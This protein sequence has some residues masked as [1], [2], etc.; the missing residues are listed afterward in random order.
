[1]KSTWFVF[2]VLAS[3]LCGANQ[4]RKAPKPPDVEVVEVTARRSQGAIAIDGRVRNC[5]ERPIPSLALLFSLMAPGRQVVT[6][7]KGVIDEETL[8]PGEESEFHWAVKEHVRA[9]EFQIEAVDGKGRDL[10]VA[11]P[12]PYI[13]E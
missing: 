9:V 5:G 13:I 6:T 12:G 2:F 11:K 7:Q 8:N 10:L 4:K 1:M 3:L